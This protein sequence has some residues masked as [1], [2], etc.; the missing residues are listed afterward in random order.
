MFSDLLLDQRLLK[1]VD[2]MGFEQP[3][4]VQEQ[5]IPLAMA[6]RDGP[7]SPVSTMRPPLS[8]GIQISRVAAS[9]EIGADWKNESSGPK[10]MNPPPSARRE[11]PRWRTTTPLGVPVDP[12]V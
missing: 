11:M 10:S 7:L 6:G 5:A 4:P 2:K 8:S 9:N 3:T 12:L 1:S